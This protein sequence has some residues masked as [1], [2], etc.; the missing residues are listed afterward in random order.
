M[1][2][3]HDDFTTRYKRRKN[4]RGSAQDL[5]IFGLWAYDAAI[6]LAIAAENANVGNPKY[7]EA[8]ISTDFEGIGMSDAGPKLIRAL[9]STTFK[10]LAGDFN[11]VDGQLQSPLYEIVNMVGPGARCIGYW[12][13]E[14]GIVKDLNFISTNTTT[15][16]TSKSNLRLTIWPG[17]VSSS[18]DGV[19]RKTLRVAVPVKPDF[20]EFVRVTWNPDNSY[21]TH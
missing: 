19:T 15:Y 13:K 14:N 17:D 16:S 8:N 1:I 7:Q 18:P 2:K 21:D 12:T 3:E 6:A 5:D 10:G 4:P 11:L 9:S 20:T